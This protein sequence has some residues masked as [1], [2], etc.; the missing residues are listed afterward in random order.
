MRTARIILF[1][2]ISLSNSAF[3]DIKDYNINS[4]EPKSVA[5]AYAMM[6]MK[7]DYNSMTNITELKMKKDVLETLFLMQDQNAKI[8]MIRVSERIISFEIVN[9]EVYTN[10]NKLALASIKWIMK[11]D[12]QPRSSS[13]SRQSGGTVFK[14]NNEIVYIDYI[15]KPYND[16]WK[17]ISSKTR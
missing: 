4:D 1:I 9:L 15:L 13:E 12:S 17:I 6:L 16:E 2:I 14:K 7:A 8:T 3:S 10:D 5:K 11:P